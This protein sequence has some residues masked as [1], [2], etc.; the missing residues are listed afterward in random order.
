MKGRARGNCWLKTTTMAKYAGKKIY[1]NQTWF[2]YIVKGCGASRRKRSRK[3]YRRRRAT[4]RGER[5]AKMRV[6]K[7]RAQERG[8]KHRVKKIKKE[9]GAKKYRKKFMRERKIKARKAKARRKQKERGAKSS[10]KKCGWQ[11]AKFGFI[12]NRYNLPGTPVRNKTLSQCVAICK[13]NRR[14]KAFSYMKGR[15]RGNCWLKTTT[16][17]KYAGKKIYRNQTWFTYIVKG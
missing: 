11:S 9:L 13:K 1:R 2:T 5:M 14:C 10:R 6:R 12:S 16:M 17:A 15:A 4:H 8:A 3:T 7:A